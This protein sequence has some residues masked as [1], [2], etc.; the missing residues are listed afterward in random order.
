MSSNA[1]PHALQSITA[2]KITELNKQRALYESRKAAI[3]NEADQQPNLREKVRVLLEGVTRI[4]GFP[5]DGLDK[6]DNE[7]ETSHFEFESDLWD[8]SGYRNIRRFLLQ[9]KYDS[10]ISQ[11]MLLQWEEKLKRELE[12]RSIKHEHALFFSR[13]VTEWLENPN[14]STTRK[15]DDTVGGSFESVGR[16]EMHEQ[17]A[18]WEKLVFEPA[19]TDPVAIERYLNNLFTSTRLSEQALKDLRKEVKAFSKEVLTTQDA[20]NTTSLKWVTRGVIDSDIFSPEKVNS[21]KIFL[22]NDDVAQEVADVLNMRLAQLDTWSW[23]SEAIPVEMRRQLNGKYRVF[24]DEDILDAL[25][26]Q[27][28][29]VRWGVKFKS[30]F[31]QFFNSH[32]WKSNSQAIPK[33]DLERRQYF[34]HDDPIANWSTNPSAAWSVDATRRR[35]YESDYFMS[36]LRM[37]ES[38]AR[39]AYDEGDRAGSPLALKHS[40][41]H[42]LITEAR[43]NTTLYGEMTVLRSDFKWFGP[44]LPHSTL[45]A[46]MKFFDMPEIWLSF[47]V[48]FL[49]APLKFVHDGPNAPIRV[50]RR[51]VPMSHAISDLLGES[52]LFCMDF[53]VNQKADGAFLYRLHDDFWF[54]GQ[55]KLCV[56]AWK[57]MTE[58]SE[59]MGI[60]FNEEKTGTARLVSKDRGRSHRE[61]SSPEISESEDSDD[62]MSSASSESDTELDVLPEGDVRWGFLKLDE[63]A[64]RFIID[65]AQVDEHIKEL[66]HQLGACKSVFSWIQAWNTY[67]ARFFSNNFG[68]PARCFGREHIEMVIS[69]LQRIEHELFT[70]QDNSSPNAHQITNVT[71]YLRHIIARRFNMHDLPDGFF[72]F[73]VELGGLDLRNPL[74]PSLAMREDMKI[75]PER[76]LEKAFIADEKLYVAAKELFEKK[77]PNRRFT[78]AD[79]S[80]RLRHGPSAT[81]SRSNSDPSAFMSLEEYNK[82]IEITSSKLEDAYSRLL[83]CPAEMSVD[84]TPELQAEQSR[85]M[86]S[87]TDTTMPLSSRWNNM[88]PYWRWVAELY[89]EEMTRRYGGLA[90]V[91]RGVVP[92]GVVKVLKEG[93]VKWQG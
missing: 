51:G 6:T 54:W 14:E 91:E 28:V 13:L 11:A 80:I 1:L 34:L 56:R 31:K 83:S 26:A 77:G 25:F 86:R 46:V 9:S 87:H 35:M 30:L 81:P 69:T 70:S 90:V 20:F 66:R 2:T 44:S 67:M 12:L 71:D 38:A 52:L 10:S 42:L 48:R 68:K 29:G 58:F 8:R 41:L 33:S 27:Y 85:I 74:I 5:D 49:E 19:E 72:Y 62:D 39:P 24:M 63:E 84:R 73:P 3:L 47:L 18:Q 57:A 32:A 7:D 59:V 61:A 45:L 88:T 17:R 92:L 79:Y 21:L 93:K 75:T 53:A 43:L 40:L 50:R 22:Q 15:G 78:D 82:Y 55:E 76:I 37:S 4:K 16:K 89:R 64:G 23:G 36:Q 60:E 65:Q